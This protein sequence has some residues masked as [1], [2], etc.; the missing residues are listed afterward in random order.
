MTKTKLFHY[1]LAG[2]FSLALALSFLPLRAISVHA[3]TS[4][5]KN[6]V[7]IYLFYGEGC[8]HCA[9]A[10]SYFDNLA[11]IYP[12][13]ELVSYEV[14]YNKENQELFSLMAQHYEI[15]Q[16]AV[17]TIFF[18]PYYLQGYSEE[19]NSDFEAVIEKCIN[20]NCPD[21]ALGVIKDVPLTTPVSIATPTPSSSPDNGISIISTPTIQP[22][23]STELPGS[24]NQTHEMNIPLFGKVNLDSKS[25]VVSTILI[26]LVDGF[27]PCSLWALTMLLALTLHT[28][29]RKKVLLIGLIFLTVTAGI[30]ALFIA[31]LFSVLT[32]TGFMGWIRILVALIALVF[33]LVNIKDYFWYKEGVSFTIKDEKKPGIFNKMR[34]VLDA[35]QS[36]GGLVGATVALSAGVSLVEF[37]CT[38][39]FPV[40]WTNIL[41]SNNVSGTTF[42]FLL[43]LYMFIYQF[44][45]MIIF[46]SSVITLK[47]SRVEEKHGRILK[48]ISGMLMLALS[49]VML[50]NPSLM[51]NLSSSLIIFGIACL[52]T[53]AVLLIHRCLLPKLGI[54][55]GSNSPRSG[56]S[57]KK[58]K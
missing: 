27:N 45:E 40:I 14:Y 30:Y 10:T 35:S 6:T 36:F 13:I 44:D 48:L 4:T 26:A 57:G 19:M 18:G 50:I 20:N 51:N 52:S 2:I 49:V 8:P 31:G 25:I 37:S 1:W 29:S 7:F 54:H 42:I 28:G 3:Q 56:K 24:L 17:P 32:I 22:S 58:I 47:A 12:E 33:A 21:L 9:K 41:T 55:I 11:S 23:E 39:G 53:V 38:A 43:I 16:F 46:F 34:T 5:P 15:E